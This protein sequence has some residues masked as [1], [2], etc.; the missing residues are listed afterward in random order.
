MLSQPFWAK[1]G[2]ASGRKRMIIR[3]GICLSA[4]YFGMSVCDTPLQLALLRFLNGA[5]TGFIPGSYALIATN[6][7]QE[8]APKSLATAQSRVCAGLIAGPPI[9]GALA[10]LAG[11]RG[12]MQIAGTAVLFSTFLVLWLVR[13]PNKPSVPDKTSLVEDIVTSVRS[14]MQSSLMLVVFLTGTASLATGP[15]LVLHLEN[16][17]G[18]APHWLVGP[19]YSLPAVAFVL[20]ARL[21][22]GKGERVGYQKTIFIGMLIGGIL[23]I[24]LIFTHNIWLFAAIYFSA[25]AWT[26]AV[27]PSTAALTCSHIVES[28]RGRSYAIQNSATTL[29]GLIAPMVAAKLVSAYGIPSVFAYSSAALIIG[30]FVFRVYVRRWRKTDLLAPPDTEPTTDQG[31]TCSP[32]SP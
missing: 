17:L 16:I 1:L 12:S 13:E 5:L 26:S 6:T 14:P 29:G 19:V 30:A 24:P 3:A 11:Y 28:F 7:P 2:D 31:Y 4:V 23:T 22:S 27:S 20:T 25:G 21:W 8:Y 15:Y 32:S 10:E 18:N 9:G